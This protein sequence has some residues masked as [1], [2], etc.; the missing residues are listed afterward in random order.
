MLTTGKIR[1]LQECSFSDGLM[2]IVAIDHRGWALDLPPSDRPRYEQERDFKLQIAAAVAPAASAVLLD[3][4][5]SAAQAV[6]AGALPGDTG[7]VVCLEQAGYD[8]YRG[9]LSSVLSGWSVGQAKQM[10]ASMVKLFFQYHP[11]AG[12]DARHQEALIAKLVEDA[13]TYDIPFM[14]EPILYMLDPD[15]PGAAE[16]FAARRPE[17]VAESARRIGALGP[18]VLK[19]EFPVDVRYEPDEDAWLEACRA[20]NEAATA[21]WVLLSA[22][23]DY[24]TFKRQFEVACRAGASGHTTGRALWKEALTLEGEA[25]EAFLR[26]TVTERL[27]ELNRILHAH[28]RPWTAHH[29]GLAESVGPGWLAS[30]DAPATSPE[31][32]TAETDSNPS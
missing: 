10:G 23:V 29:P 30:Y 4:L 1:G 17:L 19:L 8:D 6:A 20:L 15:A 12:D 18:D 11:E 25:R 2:S 22:G 3:P 16:R 9:P 24:A 7:L 13:A 32:L 5:Y 26:T 21:P 27:A 31:G 14:A 28:G